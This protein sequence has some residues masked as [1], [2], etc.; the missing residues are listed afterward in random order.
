[1]INK[2][3][4]IIP[5]YGVED[6]IK[7]CLSSVMSQD[8]TGQVECVLVDDCGS[9]RSIEIAENLIANYTGDVVFRILHHECNRGLSAARNTGFD[10]ST[11]DYV[12]FL[13]SD[14][15]LYPNALSSLVDAQQ[16]SG[17]V[18]TMGNWNIIEYDTGEIISTPGGVYKKEIVFDDLHTLLA[19][20][21]IHG[22]TPNK[23]V[24]R[25]FWVKF[26]L[27]QTAGLLYE[28]NIWT[29]KVLTHITN[30]YKFCITPDITY[31][32]TMRGGSIMHS[33]DIRHIRS[34]I[35][36]VNEIHYAAIETPLVN[37]WYAVKGLETFKRTALMNVIQKV[38]GQEVYESVYRFIRKHNIVSVWEYLRYNEIS[39]GN[40]LFYLHNL[41]P[42]PLGALLQKLLISL[43][44]RKSGSQYTSA[45][46]KINLS[47]ENLYD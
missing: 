23:L 5:V 25:D 26:N 10:G 29:Y 45:K 18:V 9:D 16:R 33:F 27:Y 36:A 21:P 24:N 43:Q 19:L 11:G 44:L 2:V 39:M 3:S 38:E 35:K 20:P 15:K 30:G 40:K 31:I 34:Y 37:M 28:D 14:D 41:L 8:Y 42:I 47:K 32:Y 22:V 46:L 6:Y 12:L 1:M 4:I 13:D 7:D 17:A